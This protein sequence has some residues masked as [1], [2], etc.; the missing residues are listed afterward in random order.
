MKP[1]PPHKVAKP[2]P[3]TH[4]LE[5]LLSSQPLES[6]FRAMIWLSGWSHRHSRR[7][8]VHLTRAASHPQA[9]VG[10]SPL[11]IIEASSKSQAPPSGCL[12][13][14]LGSAEIIGQ[15]PNCLH[16]L[17]V[18]GDVEP[19]CVCVCCVLAVR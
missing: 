17:D 18:G 6:R 16:H 4:S 8:V 9:I 10:Q 19:A 14:G 13:R 5:C 1:V 12:V 15:F 2:T 7:M 11:W 3:P